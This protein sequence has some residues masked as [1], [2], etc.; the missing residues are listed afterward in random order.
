MLKSWL[1]EERDISSF[2]AKDNEIIYFSHIIDNARH[3]L[4]EVSSVNA[5]D[6]GR[7]FGQ[8][9]EAFCALDLITRLRRIV[10][11]IQQSMRHRDALM[12]WIETGNMRGLFL[13]NNEPVQIQSKELL[14]DVPTRWYSTYQMIQRCIEMRL[15]SP[16]F[17]SMIPMIKIRLN[18]YFRRSTPSSLDQEA[19][20]RI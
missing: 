15:V 17:Y 19:I 8:S 5:P 9:F 4:K 3:V 2:D 16:I 11:A 12:E 1:L 13:I 18:R 10:T 6:E 14:R 7:G 20:S